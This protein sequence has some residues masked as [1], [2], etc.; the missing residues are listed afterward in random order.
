M[1]MRFIDLN[2]DMGEYQDE[3]GAAIEEA[4]FTYI[5]SCNIA[6]GGHAG[7]HETMA[8]TLKLAGEHGVHAGAHPSYPDRE[9]FG[10][11]SIAIEP[12][13]LAKS[14]HEQVERLIAVA[15]QENISLHHLKPH[16]ALYNDAATNIELARIV[17]ACA[18]KHQLALVGPPGSASET[19]ALQMA[20]P[21]I[22]E[23]FIDRLYT[24]NGALTP[25]GE[26]GAIIMDMQERVQQ[27]RWLAKG[28][29]L[30][31]K[32]VQLSLSVQTLCIHSDSQG[33]VETAKY[34]R[35][36]LINDGFD[37]L[38]VTPAMSAHLYS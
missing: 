23:G 29:A 3:A 34:V 13:A 30:L 14:L 11:T 17:A 22:C 7:T 4:L 16:G 35:E 8:R 21:F 28:E 37:V 1:M 5:S 19:A 12:D 25:R 18:L 38:P 9:G 10:R 15:K 31:L 26:P 33:A 2:A 20:C 27:A 6:C 36:G 32:S 24:A